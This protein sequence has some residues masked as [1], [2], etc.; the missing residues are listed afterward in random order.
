MYSKTVNDGYCCKYVTYDERLK[1]CPYG[2]AGV[3]KRNDGGIVL[4]SYTTP[5][6]YIDCE[7]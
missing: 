4:V 5:V 6:I 1:Y 2:S 7:G 3:I